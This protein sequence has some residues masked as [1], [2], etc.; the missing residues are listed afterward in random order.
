MV[1]RFINLQHQSNNQDVK[2]YIFFLFPQNKKIRGTLCIININA[3]HIYTELCIRSSA[4]NNN[5]ITTI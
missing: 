5:N 2:N 4:K 3:I 1:W